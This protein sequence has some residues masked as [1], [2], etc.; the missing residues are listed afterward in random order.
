[1]DVDGTNTKFKKN[2]CG[3]N[4]FGTV[5]YRPTSVHQG[6]KVLLKE[7]VFTSTGLV[8]ML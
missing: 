1:M 2:S 6:S 5:R 8:K 3:K 4:L 7:L